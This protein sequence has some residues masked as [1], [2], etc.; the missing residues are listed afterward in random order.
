[1]CSLSESNE[2]YQYVGLPGYNP[3]LSREVFYEYLNQEESKECPR[4]DHQK[5]LLI[6][7]RRIFHIA[8]GGRTYREREDLARCYFDQVMAVEANTDGYRSG[9]L[10]M[11]IYLVN[12]KIFGFRPIIKGSYLYHKLRRSGYC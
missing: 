1:M 9:A 6:N 4:T 12:G 7:A 2:A 5:T 8:E 11:Q 10:L 3:H